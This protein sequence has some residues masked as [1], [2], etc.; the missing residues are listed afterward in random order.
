MGR[1]RTHGRG[2]PTDAVVRAACHDGAGLPRDPPL[3]EASRTFRWSGT[4]IPSAGSRA[5]GT[6]RAVSRGSH[7]MTKIMPAAD[8]TQRVRANPRWLG[9]ALKA[10][11]DFVVCVSPRRPLRAEHKLETSDTGKE[12]AHVQQEVLSHRPV[13]SGSRQDS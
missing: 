9:S 2:S 5:R 8:F 10:R 4:D 3:R 1:H 12:G 13:D 6:I 11:Y 7:A